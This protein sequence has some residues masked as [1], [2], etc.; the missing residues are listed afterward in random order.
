LAWYVLAF[1]VLF[2]CHPTWALADDKPVL[3]ASDG[4]KTWYFSFGR[5]VFKLTNLPKDF[6]KSSILID[7]AS[8]SDLLT[9]P[10]PESPIGCF[11]NP[12]QLRYFS[13]VNWPRLQPVGYVG[14]LPSQVYVFRLYERWGIDT[15]EFTSKI[16]INNLSRLGY[17]C[18]KMDFVSKLDDGS[19]YCSSPKD[20]FKN[21]N[22]KSLTGWDFIISKN[23]YK[24]PIGQQ[25]M[26]TGSFYGDF[27]AM[28][29]ID[30]FIYISYEWQLPPKASNIKIKYFV[31]VDRSVLKALDHLK[32]E[33][34]LWPRQ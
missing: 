6:L 2:F 3:C 5:D 17:P 11:G 32:V 22:Q 15:P 8:S 26:L 9:S 4:G 27:S 28:Y 1:W 18:Y 21:L 25:F 29:Q 13:M 33:N 24:T 16:D 31:D 12:Q 14:A 7:N 19:F 30:P 10:D 23:T 20:D 34:Y